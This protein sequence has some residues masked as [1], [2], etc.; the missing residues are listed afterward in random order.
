MNDIV[1]T[2]LT[3]CF[4]YLSYTSFILTIGVLIISFILFYKSKTLFSISSF[5]YNFLIVILISQISI[6][7]LQASTPI[8]QILRD[9][10]FE[11]IKSFPTPDYFQK[12]LSMEEITKGFKECKLSLIKH[13]DKKVNLESY[14]NKKFTNVILVTLESVHWRYVNIFGKE[15]RTWPL[16]SKLKNR[17]EIFPFIYS[18][19]PES[20]RG[21]YALITGLLPYDHLFL[22]RNPDLIHK[23]LV[24]ELKNYNYNTYLFSS[25]SINDGGLIHIVKSLP[26]DYKFTY[27][28]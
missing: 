22:H 4:N 8:P 3:T 13:S 2:T 25:G 23:S 17:L 11:L 5:K 27:N 18:S 10:F 6:T 16:M 28:S 24:N 9:P 20:T 12:H 26:F 15:P 1:K 14:N 19:F 21:D 7:L